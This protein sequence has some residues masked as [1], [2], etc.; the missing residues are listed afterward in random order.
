MA[1]RWVASGPIS[2]ILCPCVAAGVAIIYLGRRLLDASRDLPE[3]WGEQPLPQPVG[4]GA[5][6]LVLLP[7]GFA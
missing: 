3:A 2:R 5:S 4:W 7:M 6:C 1:C